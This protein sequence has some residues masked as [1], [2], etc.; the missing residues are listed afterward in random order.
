MLCYGSVYLLRL[1]K[2]ETYH[3]QSV[4][5]PGS[6]NSDLNPVLWVPTGKSIKDVDVLSCV[7]VINCSFT[8]DLESVLADHQLASRLDLE[9]THSILMLTGPHQISS[10]LPSS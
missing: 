4:V 9:K 3:E 5:C 8:V 1:N 6:N 7:E 2:C 10:L